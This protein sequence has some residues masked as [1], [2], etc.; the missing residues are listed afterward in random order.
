M[1]RALTAGCSRR[2]HPKKI[3]QLAIIVKPMPLF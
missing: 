1:T 3:K 2:P